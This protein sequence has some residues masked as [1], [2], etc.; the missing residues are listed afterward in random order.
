[1]ECPIKCSGLCNVYIMDRQGGLE[2][3]VLMEIGV[4]FEEACDKDV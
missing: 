4:V 3:I 1:M 2:T